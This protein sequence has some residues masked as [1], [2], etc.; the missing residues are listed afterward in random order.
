MGLDKDVL[1]WSPQ[2]FV[3][4]VNVIIDKVVNSRRR[5]RDDDF[6]VPTLLLADDWLLLA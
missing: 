2:F 6:Y 1:H 5:Y 4:V 3:T